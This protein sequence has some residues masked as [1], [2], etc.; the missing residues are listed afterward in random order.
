MQRRLLVMADA[1]GALS[2]KSVVVTHQRHQPLRHGVKR[3]DLVVFTWLAVYLMNE[4][5]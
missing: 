4:M 1:Q 5:A 3:R 2:G